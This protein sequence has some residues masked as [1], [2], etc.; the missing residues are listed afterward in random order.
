MR[1]LSKFSRVA[2]ALL[3]FAALA[4]VPSHAQAQ[5]NL[6]ETLQASGRY[7]TLLQLL[8]AANLRDF[9]AGAEAVTLFAPSD[10]VFADMPEGVLE[11]FLE[12]EDKSE[13]VR[14]LKAHVVVGLHTTQTLE[15]Y[16]ELESAEGLFLEYE[17]TDQTWIN[18]A[19]VVEADIAASNGVIHSIDRLILPR[20]FAY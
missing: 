17:N 19:A 14:L 7:D 8:E 1:F 12:A 18:A 13:L 15:K 4:P 5:S 3:F 2:V 16:D 11:E 20:D 10:K 9:L 6:V